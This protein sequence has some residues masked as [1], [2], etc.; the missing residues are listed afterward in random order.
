MLASMRSVPGTALPV[1]LLLSACGSPPKPRQPSD[2]ICCTVSAP[3]ARETVR[4]VM[5]EM[6]YAIVADADVEGGFRIEA[7]YYKA[8]W[9]IKQR[10]EGR[11]AGDAC[12]IR[13]TTLT[14][15]KA[16]VVEGG[17]RVTPRKPYLDYETPE[18]DKAPQSRARNANERLRGRILVE[19][20]KHGEAPSHGPP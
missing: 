11:E 19:L 20:E 16:R 17:L 6:D 12:E 2:W 1:V 9:R 8:S 5:R 15:E 14:T 18:Y 13:V 10:V 7:R 4:R 3:V